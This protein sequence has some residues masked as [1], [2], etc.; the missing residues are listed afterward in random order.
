[1]LTYLTCHVD[2]ELPEGSSGTWVVSEEFVKGTNDAGENV[3][4][5]RVCVHGVI[6]ADDCFGDVYMISL[7]NI[8]D[9]MKQ[10]LEATSVSLPQETP[11]IARL[12]HSQNFRLPHSAEASGQQRMPNAESQGRAS[13]TFTTPAEVRTSTTPRYETM[14][15]RSPKDQVWRCCQCGDFGM[16]TWQTS[17]HN[18][19]HSL[20]SFNCVVAYI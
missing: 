10:V 12:M 9:D 1:V 2:F 19:G 7:A 11:A 14:T 15:D 20:C 18:C 16:S 3:V 4:S 8:M 17:C 13:A 5:R 6:V